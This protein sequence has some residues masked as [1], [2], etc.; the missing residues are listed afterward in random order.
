VSH[1]TLHPWLM[2]LHASGVTSPEGC[3]E[4]S[5]GYA[6]FAYPG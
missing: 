6:F 5:P 1:K 4:I 2:F 3:E